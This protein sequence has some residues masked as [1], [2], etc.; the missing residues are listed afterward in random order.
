[1]RLYIFKI[2]LSISM[3]TLLFS[4][5][6]EKG[7]IDYFNLKKHEKSLEIKLDYILDQVKITEETKNRLKEKQ[8]YQI[9][10]A[11]EY[12]YIFPNEII[13]IL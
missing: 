9:K 10:K 6:K 3:I 7:L 8:Y 4:F 12:Y 5:I 11:R 2:L 13:I 1:M